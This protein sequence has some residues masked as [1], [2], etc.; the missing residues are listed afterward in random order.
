MKKGTTRS[1]KHGGRMIGL[2][3]LVHAVALP[4]ARVLK[5]PC[6]D[7]AT[8]DLRPESPCA[9]RQ[10]ALNKAVPFA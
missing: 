2:G 1:I 7:P 3:D 6:V 9:K 8:R 10:R 5:L 4:V